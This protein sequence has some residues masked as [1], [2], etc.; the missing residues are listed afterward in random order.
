MECGYVRDHGV[1]LD[2]DSGLARVPSC[3]GQLNGGSNDIQGDIVY[4]C[5][6]YKGISLR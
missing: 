4:H 3:P 1:F 5:I 6:S 2:G